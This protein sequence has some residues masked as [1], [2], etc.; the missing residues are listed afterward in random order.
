MSSNQIAV[1]SHVGRDLIQSAQLFKTEATVVWEY[2]VNSLQYVDTGTVPVVNVQVKSRAKIIVISDN[3]RGMDE[4]GLCHFFKMHA[5][6]IDRRKGRPGR[7]KFGTGKSAAFG[8]ARTLTVDT[9]RDGI[10]NAVTLTRDAV[11]QSKG[12]DIPLKWTMQN[13]SADQPNG[14]AITI[15]EIFLP[16]LDTTSISSYV[17]R[18][19]AVFRASSPEVAVNSH[20]CE[21]NEPGVVRTTTFKPSA[22]QHKVI[23]DVQ[24]VIKV[25]Q[26]PLEPSE[27]GVS[28]TAG[29]GNLVAVETFDI[30]RKEWGQYLF[31]DVDVPKL[32]ESSEIAAY[33][34]TRS[35]TLNPKHPVVAVLAGFVGSK[36]EEVRKE[37]VKAEREARKTEQ[38]RRLAKESSKIAEILN[39]D[40]QDVRKRLRDIR[41]TASS[42][43][44]AA[45]VF[46]DGATA[47]D[48][49]DLW[50]AG[51]DKPGALDPKN[52]KERS[53]AR[54]KQKGREKPDISQIGKQVDDGL[55]V[56]TPAGGEAGKK[57][58]PRGGFNVDYRDLGRDEHRSKYD[59]SS[60]TILINLGHP[61]LS[62]ALKVGSIEDPAFRRLSYEIAFSEY[63]FAL[64]YELLREDQA[65]PGDDLL[66]EVRSTLNR[67]SKTAAGLYSP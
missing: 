54:K 63:A 45:A 58:R 27:Q 17:E 39:Q 3:G 49:P 38:A 66:Y 57:S 60:M 5:E 34:S 8:I 35:L 47:G 46:G 23:G 4:S 21:Y 44:S 67:V 28:V 55:D 7:G 22:S 43:G 61:V 41:S 56:V 13:Q 30:D 31:G 33:D 25:A 24:L 2:V 37:L 16:R 1:T 9:V 19:L 15:S 59:A 29:E 20:V 42:H 6:N 62:A 18:H 36:L 65:M 50:V 51:T 10:R 14:T 32:E 48:E 52:K 11:A 26:T 40:F 53:E 12:N 64:G